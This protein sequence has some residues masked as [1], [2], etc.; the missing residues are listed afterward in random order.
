MKIIYVTTAIRED[1]YREFTKLWSKAPN[2]SNQN[3]HNKLI[4]SLAINNEVEVI[5]LR[6]F[7]KQYC[8][9]RSLKKDF[10]EDKNINW[11]Y[12]TIKRG[13]LSRLSVINKESKA[14]AK[15]L[16][17]SK[18][19]IFT[20][21]INPVCIK[22][23]NA[24]S[25]INNVPVIGICTDSPSNISGTS[26]A[27]TMYLLKQ[28]AKCYGYIALTSDLNDLFNPNERK[29]LLIEGVV[30]EVKKDANLMSEKNPYFFFGGALLEKYGVFNLIEA[31]KLLNDNN[32]DLYLC[33]HSGNLDKIYES[34]KGYKNIHFLGT[35]PV[36]HVLQ[37]EMYSLANINP[38]PFNMD[39]DR[40]S[41]PSKTLEYLASGSPTI[42][43]KNTKLQK[44]FENDAIWAKSGSVEDLHAAMLKVLDLTKKER[45]ALGKQAKEKVLELY[46][47]DSINKKIN[48]FLEFFKS[49]IN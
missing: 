8:S 43:V 39:L 33:G 38:R 28:A 9:V 48:E 6:P 31:F 21:T 26:R 42:S 45:K 7:S 24:I 27:Y 12:L 5:S 4:R 11:H 44:H 36:S 10:K 49:G 29:S 2:P 16:D 35:L 30:E 20:D 41:I 23:A 15:S 40:L 17:L 14:I 1:D 37:Y 22:T 25:K 18:C 34:I 32:I 19:I 3:F 46:S 47:L 13:K